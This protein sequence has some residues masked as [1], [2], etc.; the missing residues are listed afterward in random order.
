MLAEAEAYLLRLQA[1]SEALRELLEEKDEAALRVAS[2]YGLGRLQSAL[3]SLL[4]R[5]ALLDRVAEMYPLDDP[6]A[7]REAWSRVLDEERRRR[8]VETAAD[9]CWRQA[10]DKLA[11]FDGLCRKETDS[12]EAQRRELI[13]QL[14]HMLSRPDAPTVEKCL[15]AIA[16]TEAGRSGRAANWDPPEA[17]GELTETADGLKK[18]AKKALPT[19]PD[20]AVEE[21]AAQ[22]ACDFH[23]VFGRVRKTHEQ[24][25]AGAIAFDFEDL[26]YRAL[27]MLRNNKEIRARTA[28]G[29]RYL[30]IDE[31]QDTDAVQFEMASL[32]AGEPDGPELFIVGDAKQSIYYF[33]GAEVE[34]FR[35][36]RNRSQQTIPLARNFRTIPEVLGFINDVFRVSG[37]LRAVEPEYGGMEPHRDPCGAC[38]VEILM[39]EIEKD[40]ENDNKIRK[41]DMR[42][43]EADL[44]ARRLAEMCGDEPVCVCGEDGKT[45][46]PARFGDVAILFRALSDVYVYEQ[47]LKQHDVP[48]TLVA[49]AGFYQRQEIMDMRNLLTLVA[50]PWNEMALLGFLRSPMV[51]L[52]DEA[53]LRMRGWDKER[54]SIA[55]AFNSGFMP[56]ASEDAA[57]LEAGRRLLHDLRDHR[58]LPLPELLRRALDLSGYEA[59]LLGQFLGTQKASNVRK[60]LDLALDFSRTRPPRLGAFLRYLDEV[61]TQEV[62]EGEAALTAEGA[63]AV[64]L[65]TIHKAKGLEF[66]IVVVPDLSRSPQPR[67]SD[68]VI[69]D[70]DLGLATKVCDDKGEL[71]ASALFEA[72]FERHK[73]RE[74]AEEARVLYVAL[75]RAR[76]WLLLG[77]ASDGKRLKGSW[78]ETLAAH[79]ELF[80]R[81]DGEEFGGGGWRARVRKAATPSRGSRKEAGEP[82]LAPREYYEAR[83]GP[84]QDGPVLRRLFGVTDILD[85][86]P[87]V[88]GNGSVGSCSAV[89]GPQI[90]AA[91]RGTL[92]HDLLRRWDFRSSVRPLAEALCRKECPVISVRQQMVDDL[93]A[94][95][96]RLA[97]SDLGRRLA[98]QKNLERE[99][100]FVLQVGEDALIDGDIDLVLD[101]GSVVDYKTGAR[102]PEAHRRYEM[103][104]L[105]YAAACRALK[106][107]APPSAYLVYVDAGEV[108]P[109]DVAP[110]RIDEALRF[111]R[112]TIA[113]LRAPAVH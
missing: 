82:A 112:D 105:L 91:E 110:E 40:P 46:R 3:G 66:P 12:R 58:D 34:V 28:R 59:I 109:V 74:Q 78:L 15:A 44:I 71:V 111:A 83:V 89:D 29:I 62:R 51:G 99:V 108:V 103:Q 38:R 104:V 32:L 72:I 16:A 10:R 85:R 98:Q 90:G 49:G 70:P 93:A 100:P 84:V 24:L 35:E 1:V 20:P 95:A 8:L 2:E 26:I 4:H 48:Y 107:A 21:A 53:L 37:L 31:F 14:D 60:L 92:L 61:S 106:G 19:E 87:M 113:A 69:A 50:D 77:A 23:R 27:N 22:L 47:A 6:A 7:L 11:R 30:L 39:P 65:M 25:K 94:A 63:G 18:A 36:A 68:P 67:H 43:L 52:S 73:R 75:T 57:S 45:P 64:T 101:D 80:E 86:L 102:R 97:D 55:H 88:G 76:D 81:S 79:Y 17:F 96:E 54:R 13:V 5:P 9:P 41:A 33:R 56:V 42:A